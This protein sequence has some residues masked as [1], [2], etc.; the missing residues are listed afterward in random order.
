MYIFFIFQ[1]LYQLLVP[2]SLAARS[3]LCGCLKKLKEETNK[4]ECSSSATK[5]TNHFLKKYAVH[6]LFLSHTE[7]ALMKR[8]EP[9]IFSTFNALY[10]KCFQLAHL[11]KLFVLTWSL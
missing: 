6:H 9:K 1:C 11:L 10:L 7:M 2:D 5:M 8:K 4:M 3:G